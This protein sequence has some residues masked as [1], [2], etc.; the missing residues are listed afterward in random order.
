MFAFQQFPASLSNPYTRSDLPER[1]MAKGPSG[2]F[3]W[4]EEQKHAVIGIVL[5][6]VFEGARVQLHLEKPGDF[7]RER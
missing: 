7:S 3:L 5:G 2:A 4:P 1:K 6:Q